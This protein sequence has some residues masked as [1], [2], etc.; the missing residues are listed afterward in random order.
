MC[1][2]SKGRFRLKAGSCEGEGRLFGLELFGV[3][4]QLWGAAEEKEEKGGERTG[5]R[6][7]RDGTREPVGEKGRCFGVK[8][9]WFVEKWGGD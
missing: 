5:E 2:Y 6:N 3:N 7:G 1:L 8:Q 4:S 9:C